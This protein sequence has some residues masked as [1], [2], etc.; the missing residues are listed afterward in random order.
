MLILTVAEDLHELFQNCC[1]TTVAPLSEL[2]RV[3][4]MAVYF[5]FMLVVRV[6]CA[7]NCRTNRAGKMLYVILA[8]Q[9]GYVGAA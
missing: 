7:E 8:I 9:G 1:V 3:M 5:A 6:L 2:C 4:E